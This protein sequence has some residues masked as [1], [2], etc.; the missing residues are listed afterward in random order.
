MIKNFDFLLCDFWIE[1]TTKKKIDYFKNS[2]SK[3]KEYFLKL[4]SL[5]SEWGASSYQWVFYWA[6]CLKYRISIFKL[7]ILTFR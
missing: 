6:F 5:Y 1:S 2:M 4:L 3:L 7:L